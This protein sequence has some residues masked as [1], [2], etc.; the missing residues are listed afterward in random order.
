MLQVR[1][2]SKD[3]DA[4]SALDNLSFQVDDG[5]FLCIL[6]PTG[7]GKTTLLRMIAGLITPSAGEIILD[8]Q[9]VRS[10]GPDRGFVFQ[11]YALFPWRTVQQNVEFGLEV[12]GLAPAERQR[13]AR[14]YIALVGLTGFEHY[15]PKQLSG[16]MK[17]R[18]AVAR[19]LANDPRIVL[20]DEPFAALDCQ[21]R[22][23]MQEELL[24][25]WDAQQRKT[26]LFVTHNVEEAVFLAD[27]ILVLSHR[28]GRLVE[29]IPVDLPRPR[30]RLSPELHRLRGR[31]LDLLAGQVSKTEL[32]GETCTTI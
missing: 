14:A 25:V 28:P 1:N 13:T 32:L 17:Q 12:R 3:Y 9:K 31:I 6:G 23:V 19:V 29:S 4:L 5:Q 24:K 22:N 27:S 21:T 18:I 30:D 8:G 16:G 20:M 11:E 2:L 26:I 15:L 10:P 7:C